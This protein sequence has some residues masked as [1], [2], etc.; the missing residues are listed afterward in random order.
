M[1][2]KTISH[3]RILE[4]LGAGGMGV[5]YKAEDSQAASAGIGVSDVCDRNPKITLVS[6]TSNEPGAGQDIQGAV[7][8]TDDRN[9]LLRAQR[10]G[11]GTGR[12]YTVRYRATDASGNATLPLGPSWFLT[13]RGEL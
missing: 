10:N 8:G 12:V 11:T 9:F 3:Y 5:V 1:I 4:K 6:I 13:I 2:G 7:L